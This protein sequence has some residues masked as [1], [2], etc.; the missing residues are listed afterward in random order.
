MTDTVETT[1]NQETPYNG[2][3]DENQ[4]IPGR[5]GVPTRDGGYCDAWPVKGKLRCRMH[6]GAEG[7]GRPPET[8][9]Y[10]TV[11]RNGLRQ[12]YSHYLADSDYRNLACEIAIE[13]A[14]F[15]EYLSR[16][17]DGVNLTAND[18]S[19]LMDWASGIARTV[20]RVVRMENQ[21]AL[22]GREVQLLEVTIIKLLAEFLTEPERALF[23]SRLSEALGSQGLLPASQNVIEGTYTD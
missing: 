9:R 5:C 2:E 11:L 15:A 17:Q 21:S 23:A 22:T 4:P 16:F 12:K 18:I 13:R 14:L 6:G 1:E 7:S 20:E 3:G 10:S 19:R 8:G